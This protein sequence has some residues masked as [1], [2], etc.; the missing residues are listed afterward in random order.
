MGARY[1][2]NIFEKIKLAALWLA[3]TIVAISCASC[4]AVIEYE[5]ASGARISEKID[6]KLAPRIDLTGLKTRNYGG[7]N[8]K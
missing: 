8:I 4:G 1:M 5:H 2:R 6:G 3:I 7:F